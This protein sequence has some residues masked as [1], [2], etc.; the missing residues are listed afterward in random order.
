MTIPSVVL[1]NIWVRY[2]LILFIGI[3]VGAVFYPTKTIE[4]KTSMKYQQEIDTLNQQHS[5]EVK[6]LNDQINKQ[7]SDSKSYKEQSDKK[8]NSLTTQITNLS[9][10]Q[11]T[12]H[13]KLIKP[14]GTIE[15][16]DYT[17]NDIDKSSQTV[18]KVQEEFKQKI[19]SIEKKWSQI[20]ETRVAQLQKE[21]DAKSATYQQTIE[22][23]QTSKTVTVNP[24]HFGVEG[25]VMTD[26]D[27]YV[28]ANADLWGPVFVGLQS[29]FKSGSSDA[30]A[31]N[32]FGLGL[33]IRF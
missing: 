28:H 1:N 5:Q 27:Y 17:E 18:T 6:T 12:V 23:L 19:D 11:K 14:D 15:E 8:I 22:S 9:S 33:G 21:F 10:K 2:I 3:T 4:E 20:H 25:G 30:D 16:R 31:Q 7:A 29:E 13:Y 24:K 32:R 26:R